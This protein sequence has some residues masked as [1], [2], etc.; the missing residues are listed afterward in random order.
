M[1]ERRV[2]VPLARVRF[3]VGT[4]IFKSMN[5]FEKKFFKLDTRPTKPS[6]LENFDNQLELARKLK[7]V[8][9]NR[10]DIKEFVGAMSNSKYAQEYTPEAIAADEEYVNNI[11]AKIYESDSSL[12]QKNLEHS[13]KMF[14][15]SEIMQAMVVDL[16]NN[17]WFKDCKAIMTSRF[18][19]LRSGVDAV[20][21]HDRGTYLGMSF[22]FTVTSKDKIVYNKLETEWNRNT[23]NGRVQTVKYFEDPDTKEKG[24]L[25]VPKFIIG[26]SKN[27]VEEL[28]EAYLLGDQEAL[29]NHPFKYLMLLQIEEQLQT[30]FDHYEVSDDKSLEFAKKQYHLIQNMLRSMKKEIQLDEKMNDVDLHEYTKGSVALDMMRRF[31]I[32]KDRA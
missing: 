23:K 32:M 3:P 1:V 19:D 7:G 21:K 5:G 16:M 6:I 12:G 28:A 9:D 10:P 29:Q 4:H 15:L 27:D 25:L 30:V 18:D 26:A 17:N 31:R 11:E 22:D 14:Q 24:K 20:V 13:E 8:Y 2:V